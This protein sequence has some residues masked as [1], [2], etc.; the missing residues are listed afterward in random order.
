MVST[1]LD[2]ICS[3][4]W[5][6][7]KG[8]IFLLNHFQKV[9]V[10]FEECISALTIAHNPFLGKHTKT[11]GLLTEMGNEIQSFMYPHILDENMSLLTLEINENGVGLT[12]A[13]T[14]LCKIEVL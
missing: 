11:S 1:M 12:S 3:N 13:H 6:H 5:C 4:I 8:K 2:V 10:A 7:Q 9:K 14:T